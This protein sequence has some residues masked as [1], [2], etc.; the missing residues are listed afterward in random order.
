MDSTSTLLSKARSFV[1]KSA[2][3]AIAPLAMVTVAKAVGPEIPTFDVPDFS[4]GGYGYMASGS[5]APASFSATALGEMNGIVGVK[6][7][8]GGAFTGVFNPS[9]G[10]ATIY[11]MGAMPISG[12]PL[13][14]GT[15]IPFS[16]DF[17]ISATGDAQVTSWTLYWEIFDP[18]TPSS[19]TGSGLDTF[20]GS[21]N[22][23]TGANTTQYRAYMEINYANWTNGDL[24]VS[25]TGSQGIS[26][27]APAVPEPSTYAMLF[28]LCALGFVAVQRRRRV[29]NA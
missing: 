10:L 21:T 8:F 14:P 29:V 22:F 4:G 12:P 17:T 2:F 25:M 24:I 3:I 23:V 7:S 19:V 13:P 18:S 27:N 5:F 9:V 6:V 15:S 16:Y 11:L 26:F 1:R 20:F 28:G